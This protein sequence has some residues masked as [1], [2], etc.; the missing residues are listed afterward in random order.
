MIDI[1]RAFS[2]DWV[3]PPGG[4]VTDLI[5]E[6]GWTQQELARR[7]GFTT[8]HLSLLINGNAPITEDTAVRLE[9]VLGSTMRFWMTR[10]AQYREALARLE[11]NHSQ[12]FWALVRRHEPEVDFLHARMR[13]S[14]KWLP[15]WA[16]LS[17]RLGL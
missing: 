11:H 4:T 7:L 1:V 9:R 13:D 2:P 12:R 10:E 3:S 17:S 16:Q 15:G 8:K 14:W 5:E 6:R